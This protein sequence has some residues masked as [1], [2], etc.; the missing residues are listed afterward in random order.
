MKYTA[1]K[2]IIGPRSLQGFFSNLD[3]KDVC[4]RRWNFI[5]GCHK[6]ICILELKNLK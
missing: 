5:F 3:C 1:N 2:G 4:L 6:Q